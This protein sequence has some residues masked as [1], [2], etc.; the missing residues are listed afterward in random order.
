MLPNIFSYKFF[1]K[2][3][4]WRAKFLARTAAEANEP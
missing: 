2:K 3:D 1:F 4:L